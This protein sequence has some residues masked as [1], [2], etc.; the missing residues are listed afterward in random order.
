MK[1]LIRICILIIV[2]AVYSCDDP[3][4][5]ETFAVYDMQPISS[6]LS[7]RPD[8]FSEWIKVM[9]YADMYN[10]VNQAT[11]VNPVRS[12][13]SGYGSF[14]RKESFFGRRIRK[15]LCKTTRTIPFGE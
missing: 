14:I 4:K 5:D 2:A 11:A 3:Y 1:N 9:K 13:Q 12:Y 8:D 6:Y 10:A 7:T 15:S